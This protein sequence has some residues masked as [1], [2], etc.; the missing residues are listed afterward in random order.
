MEVNFYVSCDSAYDKIKFGDDTR[1]APGDSVRPYLLYG[2]EGKGPNKN[3]WINAINLADDSCLHIFFS[4][5]DFRGD[6]NPRDSLFYLIIQR[7]DY[8]VDS[9]QRLHWKIEYR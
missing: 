8:S 4:H 9:L 2:P 3:S 5:I 7:R 6:P 1:L